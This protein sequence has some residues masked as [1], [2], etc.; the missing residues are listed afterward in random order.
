NHE[1]VLVPGQS[2]IEGI[3]A[4]DNPTNS[5]LLAARLESQARYGT[6]TMNADGS[7]TYAQG[8]NF[9]GIDSFTYVLNNG[10][11]DSAPGTVRLVSP[12]VNFVEELYQAVLNRSASDGDLMFFAGQLNAGV[13]RG[14]VAA[15]FLASPEYL[16]D[17]VNSAY[18]LVLSRPADPGGQAYWVA[19]M[20]AGLSQEVLLAILAGSPEYF[21]VHGSSNQGVVA[22]FYQTFLNR[23][24]SLP[25]ITYWANQISAGTPASLVA[26]GFATSPEYRTDFAQ[27]L[28]QTWLHTTISTAA[29]QNFQ[30]S[31][32]AAASRLQMQIAVL[33]SN[34]FYTNG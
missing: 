19:Q 30:A 7:F 16:G 3:R 26:L 25:E 23:S 32:G 6:V 18:Q 17:F 11:A 34:T 29:A 27:N 5:G 1:F 4:L 9:P 33:A 20:R 2:T 21:T 8:A 13:S 10:Q 31:F 28:Y 22:G 12:N 15:E 24:A 14:Q